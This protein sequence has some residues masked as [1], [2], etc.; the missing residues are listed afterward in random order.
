MSSLDAQ[1]NTPE[2]INFL[3]RWRA[4]GPWVLAAI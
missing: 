1:P 2:A 3:E 4:G